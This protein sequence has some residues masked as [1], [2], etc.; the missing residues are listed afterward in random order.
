MTKL[1]ESGTS[2]LARN[3]KQGH[4]TSD[5]RENGFTLIEL[6]LVVII[7]P[8]IIGVIALALLS[9]FQTQ[10]S[11]SG[12]LSS[13]G[14]A[15]IVAA[16]YYHDLQSAAL[17][18]TDSAA[19]AAMGIQETGTLALGLEWPATTTSSPTETVV[20]YS[21]IQPASST[22]SA[23]PYLLMR[24]VYSYSAA[25]GSSPILLSSRVVS[26]NVPS[27][28]IPQIDGYSC[29]LSTGQCVA[30]I[31]PNPPNPAIPWS[32]GWEP[33]LGVSSVNLV[34]VTSSSVT[35]GSWSYSL[36]AVPR[37]WVQLTSSGCSDASNVC[38]LH[39]Y[40]G[41][42]AIVDASKNNTGAFS[43]NGKCDFTTT[44]GPPNNAIALNGAGTSI[45]GHNPFGT[46]V[47]VYTSSGGSIPISTTS[48]LK[49]KSTPVTIPTQ[50]GTT[51]DPFTNFGTPSSTNL[52]RGFTNVTSFSVTNNG[53]VI[54]TQTGAS[55]ETL[56]GGT[57][58]IYDPT[59]PIPSNVLDTLAGLSVTPLPSGQAGSVVLW[60]TE[61]PLGPSL[62]LDGNAALN[63]GPSGLLYAPNGTLTLNGTS[64]ISARSI[65]LSSLSCNGGGNNINFAGG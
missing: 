37:N 38:V 40:E 25:G 26:N 2:C 51:S 35:K 4:R 16:S 15:Q 30:S 41:P 50:K 52:I 18:T 64:S 43:T 8:L 34:E 12:R 1:R 53:E 36:G 9:I 60:L 55:T 54:L 20:T 32:N 62:T 57:I 65:I 47:Q 42:A 14:D 27:A 3:F 5:E 23:S 6:L 56:K 7:M 49:G 29:S 39:G 33:T 46:G 31:P 63:L 59:K 13:S 10:S 58:Y 48:S 21:T 45:N 24:N 17:M 44:G 11:V 28:L 61:S 19:L 22:A